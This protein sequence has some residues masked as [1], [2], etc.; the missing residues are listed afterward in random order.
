MTRWIRAGT[1]QASLLSAV[2]NAR[3]VVP[4]LLFDGPEDHALA[5]WARS[6]GAAVVLHTPG[7]KAALP[8]WVTRPAAWQA[9]GLPGAMLL[10][11]GAIGGELDAIA[12][13]HGAAPGSAL[14]MAADTLVIHDVNTCSLPVPRILSAAGADAAPLT[15]ASFGTLHLNLTAWKQL[16]PD[17]LRSG[18]AS[19]WAFLGRRSGAWT[20][21]LLGRRVSALPETF[22]WQPWWGWPQAGPWGK[23]PPIKVVHLHGPVVQESLCVLKFLDSYGLADAAADR[24]LL[25]KICAWCQFQQP[26]PALQLLLDAQRADGGALFKA[27]YMLACH[28]QAQARGLARLPEPWQPGGAA[29]RPSAVT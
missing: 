22:D 12:A 7:F 1:A 15:P 5:A 9:G 10:D 20:R 13:E 28:Y 26:A 3:S 14:F 29:W 4:V 16:H 23:P 25:I 19:G 24:A 6:A 21:E 8:A 2:D 27:A 11:L 18:S 17:L